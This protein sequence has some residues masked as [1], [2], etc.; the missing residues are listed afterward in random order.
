MLSIALCALIALPQGH[1]LH[2]SRNTTGLDVREANVVKGNLHMNTR[3]NTGSGAAEVE[4]ES[5]PKNKAFKMSPKDL[6]YDTHQI[7]D[8]EKFHVPSVAPNDKQ[9]DSTDH[10]LSKQA[11]EEKTN[12]DSKKGSKGSVILDDYDPTRLGV[13]ADEAHKAKDSVKEGVKDTGKDVSKDS[14]TDTSK[15]NSKS[16]LKDSSDSS[17]SSDSLDSSKNAY[18]PGVKKEPKAEAKKKP[19]AEDSIRAVEENKAPAGKT[20]PSAQTQPSV[21]AQEIQINEAEKQKLEI[22]TQRADAEKLNEILKDS[23]SSS[24]KGTTEAAEAAAEVAKYQ[25]HR[26][27][28]LVG[29][30]TMIIVSEIGDK[31]FFIAALMAMRHHPWFVFS[32]SFS[33][34]VLMTILS[35]VL[36]LIIPSLLSRRVTTLLAALL[37]LFFALKMI[38]EAWSIDKN[39]AATEELEE[40]EHDFALSEKTLASE[41]AEAGGF[42]ADDSTRNSLSKGMSNLAQLVFSP[43][44]IQ[45]FV[46]TFLGEWGDRSQIAT[47]AM[48]AGEGWGVVLT[49]CIL[50][51]SITTAIAVMGGKILAKQLSLRT[52]TM[53]GAGCFLLFA[54][55]YFNDWLHQ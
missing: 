41:K 24:E 19:T 31:T 11:I 50:G 49:G 13:S 54:V 48:G 9:P 44:W 17:I 46:M 51:H 33:A 15:G 8:D 45:I 38:K 2:T 5:N 40:V 10:A 22:E 21:Q 55:F 1:A 39:T 16:L 14:G 47:V 34:M 6:T 53:C 30:A 3:S 35:M 43:V 4:P 52:V 18:E 27:G 26:Y 20:K 42:A 7:D 29:S 25:G 28:R 12:V 32:S 37:F 23:S 36:G